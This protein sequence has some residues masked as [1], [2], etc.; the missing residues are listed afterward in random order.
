MVTPVIDLNNLN[1]NFLD[2]FVL[3]AREGSQHTRDLYPREI[4]GL[5]VKVS[6]GQGG[7]ARIRARAQGEEL[8]CAVGPAAR[9][10]CRAKTSRRRWQKRL[11]VQCLSRASQPSSP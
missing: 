6:F 1:M 11:G 5:D 2:D 7:L 8:Y 4:L 10:C 3:Q 9:G